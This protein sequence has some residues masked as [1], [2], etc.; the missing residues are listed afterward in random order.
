MQPRRPRGR[1]GARQFLFLVHGFVGGVRDYR[2]FSFLV[3]EERPRRVDLDRRFVL[4]LPVDV[5]N[6]YVLVVEKDGKKNSWR[7]MQA[8][9]LS[10]YGGA[11][12]QMIRSD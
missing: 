10:H 12:V 2:W 11:D 3:R 4:V 6:P 7:L 9:E 1:E 8:A 5:D